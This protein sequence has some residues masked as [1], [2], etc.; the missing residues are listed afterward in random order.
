MW[1]RPDEGSIEAPVP[2]PVVGDRGFSQ[3]SVGAAL[4]RR[5]G[6]RCPL[7]GR[8]PARAERGSPRVT[9]VFD[10]EPLSIPPGLESASRRAPIVGQDAQAAHLGDTGGMHADVDSAESGDPE[11][12]AIDASPVEATPPSDSRRDRGALAGALLSFLFPGLGQLARGARRRAALLAAPAILSLGTLVIAIVVAGPVQVAAS[13]IRADVLGA[14]IVAVILAGAAHIVAVIEAAGAGGRPRDARTPAIATVLCVVLIAGYGTAAGLGLRAAGNLDDIFGPG[15]GWEIPEPS[16]D[17]TATP[18][19]TPTPTAGA[20]GGATLPPV[21]HATLRP[22][23]AMDDRLNILL[24]GSDAGPGRWM[25][26]TDTMMVLT[27]DIVSGR[28]A[29]IGI[30]RNITNVPLPAES[31]GNFPD[32]RF[33]GLINAIYVEAM[34]RPDD[35]PGGEAR[36]FRALSGAV[37]EFLGIRLDGAVVV[38]L[39]GFVDLVDALGGLWI[40]VERRLDDARYPLEN[41][42]YARLVLKPGCQLLDGRHALFYAR[43]RHGNSDYDRMNRQEATIRALRN[44]LDPVTLLPQLGPLLDVAGDNL[45]TTFDR[46]DVSRLAEALRAVDAGTIQSVRL[47]P[48]DV[49]TKQTTRSL[50]AVRAMIAAIFEGPAPSPTPS[51]DPTPS[52]TPGPCG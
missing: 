39:N 29:L 31:A 45:W 9:D 37:Q 34:L 21:P 32:G 2:R 30:P 1:H 14:A 13:L 28:S 33:P 20:S 38:N 15:T 44:Q 5:I 25:L 52:G 8:P 6:T 16:F 40:D 36:G 7:T 11:A 19:P 46:N 3:V 26:R 12:G 22:L 50:K 4:S 27:V 18:V 35:F 48:P 41:G 51:L 17:P 43:T 47:L 42:R 24:I 23:W 10:R 49:P